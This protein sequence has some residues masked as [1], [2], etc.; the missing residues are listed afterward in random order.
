MKGKVIV[1]LFGIPLA[2][3]SSQLVLGLMNGCFYAVLS[4]G[5][6]VIF[7]LLNV[8]NFTHGAFFMLGALFAWMGTNYLGLGYWPMLVVAPFVAGALGWSS[9]GPCCAGSTS[10]TISMACCL[11]WA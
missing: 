2:A 6:S 5:L 11:P 7:G 10:S 9:S 8:I 4:L 3:F 1:E